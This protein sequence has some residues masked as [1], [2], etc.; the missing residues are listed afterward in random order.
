MF[1][2]AAY[3]VVGAAFAAWPT[4]EA[5]MFGE[6]WRDVSV[7]FLLLATCWPVFMLGGGFCW[8][9]DE[10]SAWLLRRQI[11]RDRKRLGL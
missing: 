7:V 6:D 10:I 2:L 9:W 11:E 5:R 8:M 4:F 1:W 3:F